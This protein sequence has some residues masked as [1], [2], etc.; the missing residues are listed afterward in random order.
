MLYAALLTPYRQSPMEIRYIALTGIGGAA[1]PDNG[2][3]V[4]DDAGEGKVQS[5]G[6]AR[7]RGW[8]AQG[9]GVPLHRQ[10]RFAFLRKWPTATLDRGASAPPPVSNQRPGRSLPG[11]DA[12]HPLQGAAIIL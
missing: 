12:G 8:P 5:R 2:H 7:V 6:K 4:H 1:R 3:L 11:P 10:G 9:P